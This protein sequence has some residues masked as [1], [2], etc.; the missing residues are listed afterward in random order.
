MTASAV[1]LVQSKALNAAIGK[2]IHAVAA[3]PNRP[4]LTC[5]LIEG[6]EHGLRLVAADNY[7]LAIAD[8]DVGDYTAIGRIN[9]P[10][11]QVLILRA[12]LAKDSREVA[13][14]HDGQTL[15]AKDGFDTVLLRLMDGK[16]PNYQ[17]A[18]V[19]APVART[20]V[21]ANQR[22]LLDS[23]KALKGATATR[24]ELP[25]NE[26]QTVYVQAEGYSE[27]IMPIKVAGEGYTFGS[28][29]AKEP[30]AA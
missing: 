29:A 10:H 30:V 9:V 21:H 26:L 22:F 27:W 23:L 17:A 7:R 20:V 6:D 8:V 3:E 2:V 13:L 18:I 19:D 15:T 1:V 16:W 11:A 4:I 14:T 12:F 25:D 5:I 28:E 24:I